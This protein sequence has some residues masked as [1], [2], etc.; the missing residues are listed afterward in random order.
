M[1]VLKHHNSLKD[2]DQLLTDQG[3]ESS[4]YCSTRNLGTSTVPRETK[5]REPAYSEA[6]NFGD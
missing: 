1:I 5:S 2:G 4:A 3:I 6:T